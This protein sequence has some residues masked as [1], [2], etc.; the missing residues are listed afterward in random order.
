M[1]RNTGK[2]M[3]FLILLAGSARADNLLFDGNLVAGTC[4]LDPDSTGIAVEFGSV[5]NKY[6]YLNT[7]TIGYPFAIHLVDCDTTVS[8]TAEVTFTGTEDDELPGLL[9]ITGSAGGVAVGL[10]LPDGTPVPLNR[11]SPGFTLV[12]GSNL[13]QMAGYVEVKPTAQASKGIV[14]GDFTAVATFEMSY[15]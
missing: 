8:D 15:P 14:E 4:T 5:V 2:V 13:L 1:V 11:P 7:R 9:S 6:L 10:E 12:Q 3:V